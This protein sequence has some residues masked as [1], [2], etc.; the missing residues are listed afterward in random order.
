MHYSVV[1]LIFRYL[2]VV[3]ILIFL[4]HKFMDKSIS[5]IKK[6]TIDRTTK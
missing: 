2:I 1:Q 3:R 6:L 5:A 4:E